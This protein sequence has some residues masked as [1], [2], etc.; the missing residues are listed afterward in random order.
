MGKLKSLSPIIISPREQFTWYKDLDFTT[1]SIKEKYYGK[2]ENINQIYPFYRYGEYDYLSKGEP[3]IPG[4]SIKGALKSVLYQLEGNFDNIEVNE[5][6]IEI[7]SLYK[8]QNLKV[9]NIKD[10]NSKKQ[11]SKIN[12][13]IF[14]PNIAVEAVKPQV[15]IEVKDMFL[16]YYIL[17]NNEF[18]KRLKILMEYIKKIEIDNS[19]RGQNKNNNLGLDKVK[20]EIEKLSHKKIFILGGYKGIIN[21]LNDFKIGKEY[22]SALYLDNITNLPYGIFEVIE[23]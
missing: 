14:M 8:I 10:K 3:Y 5:D 9:E 6:S 15:N 23:N 7:I 18:Q 11:V 4:S 21:S 16:D 22:E 17:A 19:R 12:R 13:E 2:S 20:Q 1:E